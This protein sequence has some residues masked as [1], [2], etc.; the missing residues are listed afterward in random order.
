MWACLSRTT[1]LHEGATRAFCLF[2]LLQISLL[3]APSQWQVSRPLY[4]AAA[5]RPDTHQSWNE[6]P[7][8]M[9]FGLLG[10]TFASPIKLENDGD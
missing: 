2:G 3:H 8:G 1:R 9:T 10:W 7:H 6:L 4:G 5:P